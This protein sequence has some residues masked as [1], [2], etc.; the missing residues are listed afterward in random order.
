MKASWL[1]IVLVAAAMAI[2]TCLSGA[3]LFGIFE[4]W[5]T[6][7]NPDTRKLL[8]PMLILLPASILSVLGLY[9]RKKSAKQGE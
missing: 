1:I 7:L 6:E 8:T 9:R 2:I 4:S 5:S 3:K